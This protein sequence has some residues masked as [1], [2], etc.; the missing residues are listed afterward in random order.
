MA[1]TASPRSG[2]RS[3]GQ[4]EL[5]TFTKSDP[6]R[7]ISGIGPTLKN[8]HF[9][10][11]GSLLIDARQKSFHAPELEED[12]SVTRKIKELAAP[13]KPLHGLF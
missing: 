1:Y 2:P 13:G 11:E 7:D 3:P 8:R 5:G 12:P 4:A 6:A 9:G 10:F